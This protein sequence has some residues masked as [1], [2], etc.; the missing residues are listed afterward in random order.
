L[1]GEGEKPVEDE[2]VNEISK[3]LYLKNMYFKFSNAKKYF[4][5]FA[6]SN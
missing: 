1:S 6:K 2:V 3:I 4:T 5:Y